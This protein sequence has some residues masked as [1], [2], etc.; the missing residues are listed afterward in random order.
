MNRTFTLLA[1][2][3]L[4][5][6][7]LIA[8]SEVEGRRQFQYG[9][10]A[11]ANLNT[12][13]FDE[14]LGIFDQPWWGAEIGIPIYA[15]GK[16]NPNFAFESG[17]MLSLFQMN[18]NRDF[19]VVF[20]EEDGSERAEN[21]RPNVKQIH[22]HLPLMVNY[23]IPIGKWNLEMSA[24]GE[25]G[26]FM[27]TWMAWPEDE[28]SL[29]TTRGITFN[30]RYAQHLPTLGMRAGLGAS[31]PI[32]DQLEMRI[33]T[34]YRGQALCV[35]GLGGQPGVAYLPYHPQAFGIGVEIRRW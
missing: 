10:R 25:A 2:L 12:L 21:F 22:L 15:R 35:I 34:Y 33:S 31:K 14:S 3:L 26:L 20:E 17:L 19:R 23:Q 18:A 9:L 5:S 28:V 30:T 4:S 16:R 32:N 27:S 24:G 29:G 7:S 1:L 8:Q 11:V 6:L 13:T